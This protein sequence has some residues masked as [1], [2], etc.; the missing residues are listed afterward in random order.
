MEAEVG[1]M[2]EAQVNAT[3]SKASSGMLDCLSKSSVPAASGVVRV[4][5][6]VDEAGSAV[7]SFF[8]KSTVGDRSAEECMLRVV[9][10]RSWPAPVGG[11]IGIAESELSFDPPSGVRAPIDWSEGDAGRN[12]AAARD[13]LATCRAKAGAGPLSATVIVE[14]DGSIVSVGVSGEDDASEAAAPCVV[15]GLKAIKLGSP[16]SFAAKLTL[17]PR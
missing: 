8:K 1:A 15:E 10:G 16:G 2:N 17:T 7:K 3:F 6:H 4:V 11:K 12:V 9:R 14:T 5:V 13:V